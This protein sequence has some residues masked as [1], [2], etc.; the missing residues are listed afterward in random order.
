MDFIY[1]NNE[2]WSAQRV[3]N[4]T[5][6]VYKGHNSQTPVNQCLDKQKGATTTYENLNR[7]SEYMLS[8]TKVNEL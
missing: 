6:R 1:N 3:P 2:S 7:D 4:R 8:S 5:T